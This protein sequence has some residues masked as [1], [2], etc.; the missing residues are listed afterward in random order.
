MTLNDCAKAYGISASMLM[1][2]KEATKTNPYIA[3]KQPNVKFYY[4]DKYIPLK[5]KNAVLL[6]ESA[7]LLSIKNGE[8]CDANPVVIEENKESSTPYSVEIEPAN[9]E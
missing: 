7:E 1:K 9:A 2:H 3:Q 5:D 4:I 6:E 8:G